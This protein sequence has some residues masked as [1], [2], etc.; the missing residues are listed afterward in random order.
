M[1]SIWVIIAVLF[2]VM[3]LAAPPQQAAPV[4]VCPD[5]LRSALIGIDN[6]ITSKRWINIEPD[7]CPH[8]Q[9][10][11]LKDVGK[12]IE[13]K[14]I[15][16]YLALMSPRT[17]RLVRNAF[18]ARKGY[19][20]S[21][22]ELK[23]HFASY[24]WYKP[25]ENAD[26]QLSRGDDHWVLVLKSIEDTW[27]HKYYSDDW[28][29]PSAPVLPRGVKL[30]NQDGRSLLTLGEKTIDISR[31][32]H[33]E[34]W[35]EDIFTIRANPSQDAVLVCSLRRSG[36]SRFLR[37]MNLYSTDGRLMY[38]FDNTGHK[39]KDDWINGLYICPEWQAQLPGLLIS[40]SRGGMSGAVWDT[41][42]TFDAALKPVTVLACEEPEC[43]R[44]N[45]FSDAN[46]GNVYLLAASRGG[47]E[48]RYARR[49][50]EHKQARQL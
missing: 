20:F 21:D 26:V 3:V 8:I 46:K 42:V 30:R 7:A 23:K 5:D 31:K 9:D 41:F 28:D 17:L 50:K 34:G 45:F 2:P 13:S 32:V 15:E 4:R 19:I 29:K 47:G 6:S 24:S 25:T 38:S 33:G 36:D 11:I 43:I 40:H 1:P 37:G 27:V 10:E 49:K 18:F 48:Y 39:K 44:T 14:D 16:K 35:S 12:I 22:P